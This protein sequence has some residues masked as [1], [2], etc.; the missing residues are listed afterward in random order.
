MKIEI[1]RKTGEMIERC[2]DYDSLLQSYNTIANIID[3]PFANTIHRL[4]ISCPTVN[5]IFKHFLG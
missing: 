4:I 3:R 1:D 2:Y 5:D